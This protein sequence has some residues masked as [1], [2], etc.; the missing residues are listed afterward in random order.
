M[1]IVGHEKIISFFDK[2]IG[3]NALA[4]SY[5]FVG[6]DN[7]GKRTVARHLA[8]KIL[9]ITEKQ[10]DTHPDFYYVSRL[11][12]EKTEKLKKDI[13]IV[14]A[15][16][17]KSKLGNKSWFGGYQIVIIDEAELLNEESGN[18]LLKILEESGQQRVF[19]LLT[20]NDGELLSTIRSRC[21]MFYFSLV[22]AK[23]IEA[24]LISLGYSQE[25]AS[26]AAKLSWG[27]P[28]R[29]ITLAA[30]D[31]LRGAFKQEAERWQ[32]LVNEPY[33]KKAKA[34]EDLFN[35]K[36]DNLRTSEKLSNVLEVWT[37]VWR[38]K[39]LEKIEN[40]PK[41]TDLL[42]IARLIDSFKNSQV[43]LAQNINPRLILDQI[44]LNFN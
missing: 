23:L 18:A 3:N 34:F 25:L 7:V 24:N 31:N 9:K 19:F 40:N 17:I 33:Y 32:K 39:I 44:L 14:Q 5:A 35:E 38:E 43:L 28:G 10:L 20:A 29:G 36:I 42:F 1:S 30:D 15:R 16:Q 8:A 13:S 27:R 4:Q 6:S 2:V 11:V 41:A 21:Q 26:E 37:M 12:D 22:S